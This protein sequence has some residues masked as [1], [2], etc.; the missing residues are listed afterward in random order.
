[1]NNMN[2]R[3]TRADQ[4]EHHDSDFCLRKPKR[5]RTK[6]SSSNIS[7]H[8]R[9]DDATTSAN[10]GNSN[11]DSLDAQEY[12]QE[13]NIISPQLQLNENFYYDNDDGDNDN[14]DD[15]SNFGNTESEFDEQEEYDGN[16]TKYY[17]SGSTG[18][19]FTNFTIFLLFL[20]ITKHQIGLEA[21]KDFA[22][23]VKHPE[24]NPKD[25]PSSLSTVKKYRDGLPLLPFKGHTVTINNCNAPSTSNPTR[26][27]LIFPLKNILHRVLSN[28]QLLYN[29][30]DFILYYDT[31]TRKM[32]HGQ[33]ILI[34][35][36]DNS[37]DTCLKIE[38]I[39]EFNSLPSILKS[40][41]RNVASQNGYLWMTDN[42][43]II[44]LANVKSKVNVWLMD[45]NE[46]P[47]NYKYSIE[48]IVYYIDNRWTTRPID[49]RHHHPVEYTTVQDPSRDLP[50]FKFFL[51][52]YIGN[53]YHAIGGIYL[54]IGNMKQELRR[55]LKNHFLIGFI[56]FTATTDEVLQPLISNIQE[57][58][59]GYELK[60]NNQEV[61][62]AGGLGVI[63]SD[64]LEGNE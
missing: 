22:N 33:I 24:F 20:W 64:L 29:L 14:I 54:Q 60:I 25:V 8:T 9:L 48:E 18:P 28:P 43:I 58:E 56:P 17:F 21:Y 53:A 50:I 2:L 35:R 32:C 16:K 47:I 44:S 27:A 19:Y 41:Q 63:T 36:V 13:E 11:S 57:L 42:T 10:T 12:I 7:R 39:L 62:I 37:Q 31:R 3:Q 46:P 49:L 5:S 45:I 40:R 55:K 30:G 59:H 61:W 23:I 26:Q 51:D 1:M 4:Q 15:F 6:N 52:I 34:L 38:C